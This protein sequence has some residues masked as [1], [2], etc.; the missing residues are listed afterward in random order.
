MNNEI[1]D[2]IRRF[3]LKKGDLIPV[4]KGVAY[5]KKVKPHTIVNNVNYFEVII[6]EF[7]S[8]QIDLIDGYLWWV[9]ESIIT[10]IPPLNKS[11][12]KIIKSFIEG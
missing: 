1:N 4:Q 2:Y 11:P 9:I 3:N 12:F 5:G 7:D 6:V 8:V 10:S